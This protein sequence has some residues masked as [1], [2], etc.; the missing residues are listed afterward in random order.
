MRY[1]SQ[2]YAMKNSRVAGL[3][4][5]IATEEMSHLEIVGTIVSQLVKDLPC[6][7]VD[8]AGFEKYYVDHTLGVWPQAASGVPFTATEFQSSG[9]PIADLVED[10]AAEQKA[11]KTYDNILS[12]VKDNEVADED[13]GMLPIY[14]GAEGE[15]NQGLCTGSENFW[16]VNN[17]A[18]E[19]DIQATLD[20]L[21]WVVTSKTG[22][23]S[24]SS[25]MGF[26]TPFKSF[27]DVKSDNPLVQAAVDDQ[28]SGKTAVSWNFTMMPSEEWKNK[29]GS[30]L[31]EYAQGTGDWDAVKTA[32]VD[33]WKTEYDAV[34]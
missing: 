32:F 15:E 27:S 33:G 26:T 29:L 30:A 1:M 10:M 9:D 4:N 21:K 24:L 5:D 34:H 18:S 16:C 14:I 19:A 13:L 12:L 25:D 6:D 3:L 20:F 11:R 23:K 2:K 7:E 31:L 28:N 22:I 8:V 17:A